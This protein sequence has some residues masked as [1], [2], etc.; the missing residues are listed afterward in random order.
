MAKKKNDLPP[1][2][3]SYERLEDFEGSPVRQAGLEVRGVSGGLSDSMKIAPRSYHKGDRITVIMEAV[4]RDVRFD[5]I[6]KDDP[7]GD[8][9]RVHIVPVEEAMVVEGELADII[10][11]ALA[12]QSEHI[13]RL[14]DE[15]S[16]QGRFDVEMDDAEKEL[17]AAHERGEHS[18][19][20][21]ACSECQLEMEAEEAERGEHEPANT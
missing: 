12:A 14:K 1:A 15:A 2:S 13:Q 8:Q 4:V 11:T 21:A 3:V 16:G 18:Y 9:R 5:P 7:S 6:D 20:D 17:V 10:R 19:L